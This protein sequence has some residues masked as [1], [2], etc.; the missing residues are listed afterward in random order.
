M[1]IAELAI[2]PT[3]EGTSVSRFVKEAVRVIEESGLK[4]ETG[5]MSTTIEAPDLAA[6]FRV[7]GE[8]HDVLV[9]MGVKRIHIDLRVDHRLDKEATIES[10]LRSLGKK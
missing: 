8:I 7:I 4:S 6:L 5:G 1:I 3:S 2:F 10:K 9:R